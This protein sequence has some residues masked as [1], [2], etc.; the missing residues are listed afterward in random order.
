MA[1]AAVP[2]APALYQDDESDSDP[3]AD[4]DE[5]HDEEC[6]EMEHDAVV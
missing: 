2:L 3:F 5:D 1:V 4:L 6:E